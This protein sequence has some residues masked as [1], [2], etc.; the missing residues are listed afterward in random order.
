MAIP[1]TIPV[2]GPLAPTDPSDN[3]PVTDARYGID[4]LRNVDTFADRNAIPELRRRAG[5][6]VGVAEDSDNIYRL[7]PA[8]WNYDDSDWEIFLPGD[9]INSISAS[10]TIEKDGV[11]VLTDVNT[12][13]FIGTGVIVQTTSPA[14]GQVD[15]TIEKVWGNKKYIA[16]DEEITILPDYQY[17]IYGDFEID[18]VVN[19]YGEVVIANGTIILGLSGEFNNLGLGLL[20]IVNL[21]TGDSMQVIIKNFTTVAN[22]PITINHNLGTK[23]FTF[24]VREGNTFIDVDLEHIDDDNVQLTTTTSVTTGTIVFQAKI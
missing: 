3:Y 13:N 10:I 14:N 5:M 19:N 2:T 20:K 18:G 24:N 7:L 16:S 8:P 4:G 23:D 9:G 21:A 22:T 11:P 15:V 17:W 1:G 12:I 6:L